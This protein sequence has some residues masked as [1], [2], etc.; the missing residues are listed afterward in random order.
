MKSLIDNI[1]KALETVIRYM[2][3]V[4]LG[5]MVVIVFANVVTR[6]YLHF[7]LAWSEE[8]TR[9]ML[10]WLVFLGSFLAYI[11]DEHLGLDI[12]VKKLPPLV[13]KIVLVFTNALV[14]FA[15]YAVLEG[16]YLMM[17]ANFDWLSPAAE[18]PQG[19]VYIVIPI[20][21]ALMI[22][23]TLLKTYYAI[24]GSSPSQGGT[25]C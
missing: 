2:V 4:L 24:T 11:N 19:Y 6:Y 14:I 25:P 7:S 21:C 10:V 8:V 23:Q 20:S 1:Y 13:R 5:L 9:F 17:I 3:L 18:I 15:L 12:L 16:G 22:F